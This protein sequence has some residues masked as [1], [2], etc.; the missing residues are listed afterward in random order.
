M[1]CLPF[2]FGLTGLHIPAGGLIYQLTNKSKV[3]RP[4]N[5]LDLSPVCSGFGSSGSRR[6][7]VR[8]R[9]THSLLFHAIVDLRRNQ[10]G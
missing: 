2:R 9:S 8:S 1:S 7:L 10:E 4:S 3:I 5:Y 6:C